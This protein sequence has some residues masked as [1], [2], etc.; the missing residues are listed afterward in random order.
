MIPYFPL[1]VHTAYGIGSI[2]ID[3]LLKW[4]EENKLPTVSV[5]DRETIYSWG[6]LRRKAKNLGI[7]PIF[8]V[9][10]P[11]K[12]GILILFPE[13]RRGY[14]NLSLILNGGPPSENSEGI[15]AIFI[16]G[17]MDDFL[18][19][20]GSENIYIGVTLKNLADALN[21]SRRF[22]LP[23]VF[24]NPVAHLGD[25]DRFLLL[26]SIRT[27]SLLDNVNRK[28]KRKSLLWTVL[29]SNQI[30]R[31]G[32]ELKRS[33]HKTWEIAERINF[34]LEGIFPPFSEN[35]FSQ[36]L[37]SI[38]LKEALR[39]FGSPLPPSIS[40]RIEKELDSIEG[41]GFSPYFLL[42]RDLIEFARKRRILYN[43]RGSGASS[44]IAYILGISHINPLDFDLYFERF[45][46]PG[47]REP[48]D[49]DIDFPSE[50]RDEVI[51]YLFRK[52]RGK[53]GLALVATFK[54]YR[55]RAALYDTLR[56]CG[57]SPKESRRLV[58]N[59]PHFSSP[60]IL[61]EIDVEEHLKDIF[62]R[63]SSLDGI[64]YQASLHV[65]GI[66][67]TPYPVE[68][69]I[70]L[71]N[72][73][74]GYPMAP[75]D[76]YAAEDMKLIK[77]DLLSVRGL[78]AI[79]KTMEAVGIGDIPQNDSETYKLISS[80]KTIGCFQIESPGMMALLRRMKPKNLSE[81]ASAL[82]LI[83]P[84]PTESGMKE[85]F[86]K[87]KGGKGKAPFLSSIL[88]E[89]SGIIL[90]EEQIMQIAERVAGFT[91]AEAENFRRSLK[92]NKSKSLEDKF[93]EGAIKRGYKEKEIENLLDILRYF[94]S[95]TF[96]KAHS[97]SY[98]WMA[99]R[100]AYLKTHHPAE[101]LASLINSG[102]GYY[103]RWEYIEE[104]RRMGIEILPPAIEKSDVYF[105]V[106]GGK[107]RT[108]LIFIKGVSM[109]TIENILCERRKA[110]FRDVLD[111]KRRIRPRKN[112]MVA[113]IESGALDSF[114][115][116]RARLFLKAFASPEKDINLKDHPVEMK[117]KMNLYTLGFIPGR[118]PLSLI[119]RENPRISELFEGK[120]VDAEI[121]VRIVDARIKKTKRG[122][123]LFLLLEDETGIIEGIASPQTMKSIGG[124]IVYVKGK[125]R[126]SPLRFYVEK[127]SMYQQKSFKS[128]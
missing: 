36:N 29:S 34:D 54:L 125:T 21:L 30:K 9:E 38:V 88:P 20:F 51:D 110:P 128:N 104:A 108:G 84:G 23:P 14:S 28:M 6:E 44:L 7:K 15:I 46:N 27:N 101:Y 81:L 83:R 66:L 126:G 121:L 113:L 60:L 107:L 93:R 37:K 57:F 3:E 18:E 32:K 55:A 50:S 69:Y 94:S 39:K 49:I 75:F 31:Y 41:G 40:L 42:V 103:P 25:V 73:P 99:Y 5:T 102:G 116:N 71:R 91:P 120:Y 82:A 4:A 117:E 105:T 53:I 90:Y 118:H 127:V 26:R 65:G 64:F 109:K 123:K 16:P 98:A 119:N 67:I 61:K 89:T 100:G 80:G 10:I 76:K 85:N 19:S 86:L 87:I 33:L 2:R 96:N 52:Y 74:K 70:P 63:A 78:S 97:V 68:K 114:D 13:N 24:V 43:L 95:Y 112:E 62:K 35:I 45:L 11:Y 17:K 77:L 8:G 79:G 111:F 58:K 124:E 22:N 47:R 59:I 92:G 12:D 106:E 122:E 115:T 1:R 72:S 56:A 48:P